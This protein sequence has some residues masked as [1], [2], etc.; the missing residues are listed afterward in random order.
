MGWGV[1]WVYMREGGI[2]RVGGEGG[3][4]GWREG[5]GNG[6]EGSGGRGGGGG[7]LVYV[8]SL[9]FARVFQ[10]AFCFCFCWY[11]RRN[12]LASVKRLQQQQYLFFVLRIGIIYNYTAFE[13]FFCAGLA[14]AVGT[15]YV[16]LVCG[17]F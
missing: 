9:L 11:L 4:R 1:F 6:E 16:E 17:W 2:G 13:V 7:C 8:L 14:L 3:W 15:V 5:K 10:F 12:T